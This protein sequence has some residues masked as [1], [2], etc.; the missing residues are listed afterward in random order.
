MKRALTPG[1]FDPITSGHLDIITRAAALVDEVVV[2]VAASQRKKPLFS[3]EERVELARQSTKHLPNVRVEPFDGLLVDFASRMEA[4]VVVKGLRAITDFEYEFQM[5]A[6]NYELDREIETI[7]IMSPP[8][9][10]YLSS[11]IVREIASLGGD[12]DQFVTPCV[13]KA[14]QAKFAK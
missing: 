11:S 6:L 9:H 8:Q 1:T 12:V 4:T 13:S 2:A 3:L 14:L 10:M 5:T 7:F